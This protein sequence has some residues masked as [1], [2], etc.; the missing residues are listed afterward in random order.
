MGQRERLP[1][2]FRYF[3]HFERKRVR[4]VRALFR[5]LLGFD[6][7]PSD[8]IVRAFASMYYDADP[9]ADA[10][11]SEVWSKLGA[12]QARALLDRALAEDVHHVPG[13]PQTLRA[14]FDDLESEPAWL[15]RALLERGARAFRRYGTAVFRFA[16]AITLEGYLESS[17]AKPLAL[18]GAYAGSSAKRRF[19]ETASFWIDVSEP[20]ALHRR[21]PGFAAALR[22]RV[23]HAA[24]RKRLITHPEWDLDAW[25]IPINQGDSLITLMGGSFVPGTALYALGYLTSREEIEAMMHFWRYVGHIMGVRPPW[26]PTTWNE[27]A[28]LSFVIWAK[29]ARAAGQ[30][31]KKLAHAYVRAF[32]PSTHARWLWRLEDE[33]EQ[34]CSAGYVRLFLLPSTYRRYE[35][36]SAGLSAVLPLLQ[37]PF[38]LGAEMLRRLAP[39]LEPVSDRIARAQRNR[40]LTK[41]LRGARPEF[42]PVD[43]LTR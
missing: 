18:T 19:L 14:L 11:V 9:L 4:A 1:G 26:Y 20:G 41:R 21:A 31:G 34:R 42:R 30:D 32:E 36:P 17:I 22:V 27:A 38:V 2:D 5:A 29:A 43:T 24:I 33:L 15:D 10:F 35:L 37:T 7:A 25:G 39:K 3:S 12:K 40:W 28:Q 6:L 16:G 23:M 13:L 8:E